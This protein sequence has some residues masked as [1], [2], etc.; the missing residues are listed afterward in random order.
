MS[1]IFSN[2][3]GKTILALHVTSTSFSKI[4]MNLILLING[5]KHIF[6]CSTKKELKY[7]L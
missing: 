3:K 2:N 6:M 1:D 7:R 5:N 4:D